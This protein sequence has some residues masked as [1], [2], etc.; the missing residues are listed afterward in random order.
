VQEFIRVE[1]TAGIPLL[2]ATLVAIAWANTAWRDSYA[3]LWS[4][5]LSFD[6]G[7]VSYEDT[8]AHW[9]NDLLMPL[10]FFV[11]GLEIKREI[12]HGELSGL[13]RAALSI[14]MATGGVVLPV[15]IFFSVSAGSGYSSAWGVPVATDV[16]FAL[17]VARLAGDRAPAA[18]SVLVLA[19]AVVDDIFGVLVIALFYS[20]DIS[21]AALGTAGTLLL[22]IAACQWIGIWSLGLYALLGVASWLAVLESGVHPTILGVVLGFMTPTRPLL[23]RDEVATMIGKVTHSIKNLEKQ[24]TATEASAADEE[25]AQL[26]EEKEE[27]VFGYLEATVAAS[28]AQTE[29]LSRWLNPWV[30]Y[31]VLP[32]FA[33]ANAGVPLSIDNI[34]RAASSAAAFGVAAALV[35]G[36]PIG[37]VGFA[38]LACRLGIARL[39]D[40]LAWRHIAA[41]GTLGGI[42]FTVSLFIAELALG[43]RE[44]LDA[45]KL[46]VL[47]ASAVAGIAGFLILTLRGRRAQ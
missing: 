37:I 2:I 40:G 9:V 36:K 6:L 27:T 29:R 45:V 12:V 20:S 28:E 22:L 24:R 43:D 8:L 19:F 31:L 34:Q 18:L 11:I 44:T 17:A 46:A 30:S 42:G 13:R 14:A 10:F 1:R 38:W 16:A 3:S 39:P 21:V 5:T 32:L 25:R 23:E 33:L 7:I 41:I 4:T 47:V 26:I 35:L 15:V